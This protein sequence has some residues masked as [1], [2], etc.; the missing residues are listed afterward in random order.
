MVTHVAT[1]TQISLHQF[2]PSLASHAGRHITERGED[3][4][5]NPRLELRAYEQI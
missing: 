4:V 2:C 3:E 5:F 1:G